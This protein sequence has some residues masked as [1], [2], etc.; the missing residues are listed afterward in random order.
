VE[1]SNAIVRRLVQQHVTANGSTT[2]VVQALPR[3][4]YLFNT[5]SH[6]SLGHH[7]S[8][9]Q[10]FHATF[11]D[12][13]LRDYLAERGR[14]RA[15]ALVKKSEKGLGRDLVVGDRVRVSLLVFSSIRQKAKSGMRKNSSAINWSPYLFT[16]AE[17]LLGYIHTHIPSSMCI[18]II[19]ITSPLI[20][21]NE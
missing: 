11:S 3:L 10:A 1:K 4:L 9:S 15:D 13:Q 8:P 2:G 16:I 20:M 12:A 18:P 14:L 19:P 21:A 5:S 17:S 7:I 6:P